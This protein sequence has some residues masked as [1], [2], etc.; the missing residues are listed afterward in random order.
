MSPLDLLKLVTPREWLYIGIAA[1]AV[2]G[3]VHFY[4]AGEAHIKEADAKVVHAQE[5]ANGIAEATVK[6]RISDAV[7]VWAAA[8]AAPPPPPAPVPHL[9]CRQTGGS[10]V[11]GGRG[12]AGAGDGAGAPAQAAAAGA[13][14]GFD[15][16]P[17]V[18]A[19]GLRGDAELDA[20][21]E[22]IDLLQATI[23]AYQEGGM[24]HK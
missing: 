22:Q 19:T 21:E 12:S 23:R 13:D 24:V 2:A 20:L 15:P 10:A 1:L 8:H 16:A 5:V 4:R 14:A 7:A 6:T 18:S 9:V 17:A 11:P 3:A